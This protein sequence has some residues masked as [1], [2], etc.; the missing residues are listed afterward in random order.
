MNHGYPVVMGIVSVEDAVVRRATA[1]ATA[2]L[3][4]P[5]AVQASSDAR[6]AELASNLLGLPMPAGGGPESFP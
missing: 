2:V 5:G 1:F 3:E 6:N 4:R